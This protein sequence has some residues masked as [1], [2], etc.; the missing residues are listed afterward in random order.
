MSTIFDFSQPGRNAAAQCAGP[1]GEALAGLP[2]A[3][4]R[5]A[6]PALPEVSELQ[7]VRHYTNLSA[8]NFSIDSQFYPLG[9]CTMKYNPRGA[10]PGGQPAR[11]SGPASVSA[12]TG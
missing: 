6:P 4:L 7:A 9:S 5:S 8:K 2:E 12:G 10:P 3:A 1:D 11:L